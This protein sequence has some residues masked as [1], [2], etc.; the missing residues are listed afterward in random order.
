MFHYLKRIHQLGFT[1]SI[2][3]IAPF[4]VHRWHQA[5]NKITYFNKKKITPSLKLSEE[6]TKTTPRT[7]FK[8]SLFQDQI[9]SNWTPDALLA[10]MRQ[11]KAVIFNQT[12]SLNDPEIWIKDPIHNSF[13]LPPCSPNHL[14][15]GPTLS[16]AYAQQQNA[17]IRIA[18][19]LG[20][21][22][23]LS[24]LACILTTM[25]SEQKNDVTTYIMT[26]IKTWHDQN[27]Y[28]HG[29]HWYNGMEVSIRATNLICI[30]QH[31]YDQKLLTDADKKLLITLLY[32]HK[33]FIKTSFETSPTPNN[34]YLADLVGY[35]HLLLFFQIPHTTI[36]RWI[37]TT[38]QAFMQQFLP[39]G[40]AYEG[41]TGYHHLDTELLL[42]LSLISS[43]TQHPEKQQ[44]NQLYQKALTCLSQ[45]Q[46]PLAQ[47]PFIGD[48]DSGKIITGINRLKKEEKEK[49][50]F[51]HF[52]TMG[53]TC[54]KQ[55]NLYV[56][57]RHALFQ[58]NRPTGHYH[59]DDLSISAAIN[60]LPILVDPGSGLYS[61]NPKLR[62]HFRSWQSHNGLFCS[63][64]AHQDLQ[65]PLFQLYKKEWNVQPII[66]HEA[67]VIKIISKRP[68]YCTEGI[69]MRTIAI[70]A[71]AIEIKDQVI[72]ET[73]HD[74]HLHFTFDPAITLESKQGRWIIKKDDLCLALFS[75]DVEFEVQDAFVS[76]VFGTK[77]PC[78]QLKATVK[79]QTS[80]LKIS[81][82]K[83]KNL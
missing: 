74:L 38:H 70:G 78:L 60:G 51:H 1:K 45:L 66:I 15:F 49:N 3:R 75:S 2:A 29:P 30:Y 68:L 14:P 58:T 62:H 27:P 35:L 37:T 13:L 50:Y 61:G 44:I 19:E 8:A 56:T 11:N 77:I 21:L 67:E 52:Q 25:T 36:Q 33:Q 12:T 40:W 81:Y 9:P 22:H 42:H 82:S 24:Q 65:Q 6:L 7:I 18:F 53:L 43:L 63:D 46:G 16:L 17:D 57:M 76:P 28:L 39:D 72:S 26:Q 23:Y 55:K 69:I 79:K 32:Q 10:L 31:L 54:I 71:D 47:I 64:E 34:H 20:R 5:I 4:V 73:T 48:N 83:I 41:S 80:E 59:R